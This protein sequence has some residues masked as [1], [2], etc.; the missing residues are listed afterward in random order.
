MHSQVFPDPP[1]NKS[2][3][4]DLEGRCQNLISVT[5]S[6]AEYFNGALG[7]SETAGL[8]W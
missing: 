3:T 2:P 8:G 5:K 4:N 1:A 7:S 6:A